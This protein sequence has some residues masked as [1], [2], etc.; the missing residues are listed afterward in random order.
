M[1]FKNFFGNSASRQSRQARRGA[2]TV[3]LSLETLEQ[4]ETPSGGLTLQRVHAEPTHTATLDETA[5]VSQASQIMVD[6]AAMR[7]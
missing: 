5:F 3:S 6:Y 7:P 4:R 2:S 1:W